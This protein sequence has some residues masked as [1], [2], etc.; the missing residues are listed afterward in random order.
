MYL[1]T[2]KKL[3]QIKNHTVRLQNYTLH[4]KK[5]LTRVTTT[6]LQEVK[7]YTQFHRGIFLKFQSLTG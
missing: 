3:L 2:C 6:K 7:N 5:S 4:G 1:H